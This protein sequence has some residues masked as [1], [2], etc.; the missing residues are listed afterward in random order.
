MWLGMY[1]LCLYVFAVCPLEPHLYVKYLPQSKTCYYVVLQAL[2]HVTR[3]TVSCR[4]P[5][6]F[7]LCLQNV[8]D[9]DCE[10]LQTLCCLTVS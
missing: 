10:Q 6:R 2:S 9:Q 7:A 8:V 1:T 5:L 3:T 4:Q